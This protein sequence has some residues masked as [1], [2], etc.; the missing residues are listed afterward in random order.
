MVRNVRKPTTA[1]IAHE[2][3]TALQEA[4]ECTLNAW[5]RRHGLPSLR[6]TVEHWDGY[7][8]LVGRPPRRSAK[9]AL[10]ALRRTPSLTRGPSDDSGRLWQLTPEGWHIQ[11]QV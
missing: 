8:T 5:G 1:T 11:I 6:W 4:I 9:K 3:D 2:I 7:V 10:R